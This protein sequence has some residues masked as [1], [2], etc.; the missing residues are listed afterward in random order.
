M[1]LLVIWQEHSI[2]SIILNEQKLT[3]PNV[4]TVSWLDPEAQA[5][6]LK[7][8]SHK[9]KRNTWIRGIVCHTIHGTLGKLLPGLGPD[10]TIDIAEARYQ[11]NTTREVS[12]DFTPK[13]PKPQNPIILK[14]K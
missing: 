14:D 7:E 8:V 3:I 12:W 13:T 2:M 1:L 10:T 5:L 6:G 9:S 11:T 4:K